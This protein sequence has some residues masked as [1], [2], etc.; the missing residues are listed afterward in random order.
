MKQQGKFLL[1]FLIIFSLVGVRKF[2]FQM[3]STYHC[4]PTYSI[5][6]LF[7]NIP[8]PSLKPTYSVNSVVNFRCLVS[9]IA[10]Y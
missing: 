2:K 5:S 4:L 1:M 7:I 9:I 10:Y 8:F 6:V 3:V